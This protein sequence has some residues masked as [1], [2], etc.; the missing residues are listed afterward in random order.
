[1]VRPGPAEFSPAAAEIIGILREAYAERMQRQ[2]LTQQC[3]TADGGLLCAL[4]MRAAGV[5]AS[6]SASHTA[7]C[8]PPRGAV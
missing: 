3:R 4:R 1:M 8:Q 5:A 7:V 2:A 6:H